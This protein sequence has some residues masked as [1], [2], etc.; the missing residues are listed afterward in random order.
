MTNASN[1][2]VQNF[3]PPYNPFGHWPVTGKIF[4]ALRDHP[5][6]LTIHELVGIV[7]ADRDDGGPEYAMTC[8]H[9]RMVTMRRVL[10]ETYPWL[11]IRCPNGTGRRHVLVVR[12]P[13]R[14]P[15]K[16]LNFFLTG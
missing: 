8:L 10:A 7:Y 1:T 6:G 14:R 11:T 12:R 13:G 15:P 2:T 3:F 16:A 4:D 5:H 9:A